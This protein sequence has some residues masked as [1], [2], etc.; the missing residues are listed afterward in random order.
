MKSI[1][2]ILTPAPIT[3]PSSIWDR[4][5]LKRYNLSGPRY[6]SYPPAPQFKHAFTEADYCEAIERS[7]LADRPISLY[8]HIP[9]CDTVCY[10]C[11]CNKVIT[12]NKRR[13]QPYLE[14]MYQEMAMVSRRVDSS[15][16]VEQL[17]FGGGTPTYL[18]EPELRELM[19]MIRRCFPLK[20]DDSGEYSIEVHPGRM[21]IETVSLLREIGFNRLSMGVQDFDRD[22]QQAVNRYNSVEE[23]SALLSR[24]RE[25]QFKSVSM[26]LIYGLPKQ[27]IASVVATLE[28]IIALSPDRL[29]VFNYAHLPDLFKTQR[30][31]HCDDLPEP[32]EKLFMLEQIIH[33]LTRAGYVY[34]GMDH[35]A[36]PNDELAIAQKNKRLH[37]NFQ[38]Y[39]T[40]EHCDLFSFGVSAISAVGN[41]FIQNHKNIE[42]YIAC[43]NSHRLP[44]EKGLR[45]SADDQLR[46]F[47][48]KSIICQFTLDFNAVEDYAQQLQFPMDFS[49]YFGREIEALSVLSNDGLV[50][51]HSEGIKVLP[52]GRLLDDCW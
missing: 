20:A 31:I 13:V 36:K 11:A 29:S 18:N 7:N 32:Q 35:F 43:A 39:S 2:A 28:T 40:H 48:I 45:L 10:Y 47:I 17:H 42:N 41:L 49:T 46:Q 44:I 23:V 22:V 16:Q 15:R 34:I 9:F 50:A 27:T 12:A 30:Q 14:A 1:Q 19:G 38:G 8:C 24:A 4:E 52:A 37:R 26:D 25:E 51:M 3:P 5:L 33:R 21:S 6:T